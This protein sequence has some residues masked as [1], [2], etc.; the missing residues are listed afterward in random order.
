M[1]SKRIKQEENCVHANYNLSL[2][3]NIL[4]YSFVNNYNEVYTFHKI[5]FMEG[6]V[7]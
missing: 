7:H 1:V 3:V 4:L 2:T 5:I 6:C